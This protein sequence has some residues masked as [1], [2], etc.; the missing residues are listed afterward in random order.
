MSYDSFTPSARRSRQNRAIV[1]ILGVLSI[2]MLGMLCSG[3]EILGGDG[4]SEGNR[5]KR[6]S[7]ISRLNKVARNKRVQD[8]ISI[9]EDSSSEAASEGIKRLFY[10]DWTREYEDAQ[11]NAKAMK[12]IETNPDIF[13]GHTV[14]MTC[15]K[16]EEE[17]LLSCDDC[18]RVGYC[19]VRCFDEDAEVHKIHCK[20]LQKSTDDEPPSRTLKLR[21]R[22]RISRLL[23][24]VKSDHSRNDTNAQTSL[25]GFF[26]EL[27]PRVS[28][29]SE[30]GLALSAYLSFPLTLCDI[31]LRF[32]RPNVLDSSEEQPYI[33]HIVG[34]GYLET[35]NPNMWGIFSRIVRAKLQEDLV[36][37]VYLIGPEVENTQQTHGNPT[38]KSTRSPPEAAYTDPGLTIYTLPFT[39]SKAC[40]NLRKEGGVRNKP[41][42]VVFFNAGLSATQYEWDQSIREAV[43][44]FNKGTLLAVT[45]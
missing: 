7:F 10:E 26:E 35:V 23:E 8:G 11:I 28:P 15:G 34:A 39:Y 5:T 6:M 20:F 4:E 21:V 1:G 29:F 17:N 32:D 36:F 12:S 41:N 27:L 14:C 9:L 3:V 43:S 2:Q 25:I 24:R 38:P 13:L 37:K 31:A 40:T 45:V 33:I 42:L 19:S 44:H 30:F 18:Q 16:G 22:R